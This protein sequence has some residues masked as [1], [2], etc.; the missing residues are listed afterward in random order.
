MGYGTDDTGNWN[1]TIIKFRGFRLG[2]LLSSRADFLVHLAVGTYS[3]GNGTLWA[4]PF[5]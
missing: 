2:F 3:V 5:Q 1:S 4:P